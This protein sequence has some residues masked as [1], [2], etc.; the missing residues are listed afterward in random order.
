MISNLKISKK[1]I[2]HNNT[3]INKFN[4]FLLSDIFM[5]RKLELEKAILDNELTV[6]NIN[7]KS[8]KI[9]YIR[10]SINDPYSNKISL[11]DILNI[12]KKKKKM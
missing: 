10:R 6:R 1:Y 11:S 3:I 7:N 12:H 5:S 9:K 2:D 8:L 4:T